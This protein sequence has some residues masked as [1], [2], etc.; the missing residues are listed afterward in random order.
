MNNNL[1][2]RPKRSKSLSTWDLGTV[3]LLPTACGLTALQGPPFWQAGLFLYS[4]THS[5]TH[6]FSQSVN[7]SCSPA[8][9]RLCWEL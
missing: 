6:P 1:M 4:F 7:T 9:T 2:C 3:L 8:C 5:F